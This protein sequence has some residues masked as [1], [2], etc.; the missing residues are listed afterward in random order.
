MEN[1]DDIQ[2][3][4]EAAAPTLA[5]LQR[6]N[7]F[8]V[9]ADYFDKLPAAVNERI[10]SQKRKNSESV[11]EGWLQ[12]LRW[13]PMLASFLIAI[14]FSAGLYFYS[15]KNQPSTA[16]LAAIKEEPAVSLQD[17][18]LDNVDVETMEDELAVADNSRQNT[19]NLKDASAPNKDS[20]AA[21]DDYL[22]D[23][24]FDALLS[25]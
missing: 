11:L 16:A 8:S 18:V 20:A 23:N 3:E 21:A 2:K 15:A 4:L 7:P 9:P 19:K 24:Y 17:A 5:R 1:T 14:A 25:D 12:R 22:L 6:E 13:A 10:H